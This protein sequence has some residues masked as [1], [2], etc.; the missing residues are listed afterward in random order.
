M[1]STALAA[2]KISQVAGRAAAETN[3]KILAGKKTQEDSNRAIEVQVNA[4]QGKL[5]QRVSQEDECDKDVKDD[6]QDVAKM[7]GNVQFD[8]PGIITERK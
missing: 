5:K 6:N 8:N 2:H 3:N 1:K 7:D 4:L